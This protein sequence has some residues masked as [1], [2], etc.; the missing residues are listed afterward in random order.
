MDEQTTRNV[1][2]EGVQGSASSR[3]DIFPCSLQSFCIL[4]EKI[5]RAFLL[6]I[7]AQMTTPPW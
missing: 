2:V 1:G 5:L 6:N 3:R 7:I 4:G